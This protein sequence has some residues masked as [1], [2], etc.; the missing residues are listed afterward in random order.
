MKSTKAER[1]VRSMNVVK[2]M[3]NNNLGLAQ[4]LLG[5]PVDPNFVDPRG[6]TPLMVA[7]YRGY[8]QLCSKLIELGADPLY[9]RPIPSIENPEAWPPLEDALDRAKLSQDPATIKVLEMAQLSARWKKNLRERSADSRDFV[10]VGESLLVDAARHGMLA[11]V[12]EMATEGIP[13]QGGT[14]P[15]ASAIV[16]A[17]S[18]GEY[19]TCAVLGI[20]GADLDFLSTLENVSEDFLTALIALRDQCRQNG[21]AVAAQ[22]SRY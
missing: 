1:T 19:T 13:I 15:E 22:S 17:A 21:S 6:V 20:L 7:A 8:A 3:R 5:L 16:A 18:V 14:D 2:A 11:L 4:E 12:V 9:A 10:A